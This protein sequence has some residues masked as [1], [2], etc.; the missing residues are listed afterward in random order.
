MRILDR[1]IGKELVWPFLFGVAAFTSLFFAGQNL[2]KL[3]TQVLQ[4]MPV[5]AAVELVVLSLPS[6]I[7]YTLPMSALLA[8]LVG[9]SRLSNDSEILALYA[10]GIS[11]YRTMVPVVALGVIV[12]GLSFGLTEFVVPGSNRLSQAIQ[13]HVLKEEISTSKPFV[14]IDRKTNS[15]IYVRGGLD[16]KT[17]TMHDVTITRYSDDMPALIFQARG[18]RWLGET[19]KGENNWALYDG[20]M[21]E[22]S[23]KGSSV[24]ATFQGMET[25]SVQIGESPEEI[26]RYQRGPEDMSFRELRRSIAD[27]ARGGVPPDQLLDFEV[28]LY[29]KLAIPFAALVFALIGAPLAIRPARGGTAVGIGLSVLIIFAYW[30]LWHFTTALAMQGSM[31]PVLGA[32]TADVLGLMLGM[33]LLARTAK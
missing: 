28:E 13:A 21:Y 11:L 25:R 8:V 22:L 26:A 30:F 14:V 6:V 31:P 16:A 18:A 3:T 17:R 15:T 9:F 4:G 23:P 24:A 12:T 19:W 2:L 33:I 32:F 27:L 29:N 5:M 1:L 7:V 10:S 20:S